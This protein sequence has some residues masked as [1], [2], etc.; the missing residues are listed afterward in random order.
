M[1]HALI[2]FSPNTAISGRTAKT[3]VAMQAIGAIVFWFIW[4]WSSPIIPNPL[5]IWQAFGKLWFQEGLGHELITSYVVNLKAL[6]YSLIL[7]LG[8]SYLTVVPAIRPLAGFVSKLRF[9]GL[10]GLT[11]IFTLTIGGGENLKIA[12]LTFGMSVFF[13]TSMAAEVASIPG[14]KFDHARTLRMGEWRVV[15]E[16]VILGKLDSAIE[17]MRQNAAIGW[18]MLTMVEGIVRS[19]GGVG[20]LLLT[21]NKHFHLSEVFAIQIMILL[22]GILQDYGIG[23]MK[24]KICPYADLNLERR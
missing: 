10:A 11:F 5:E 12:L 20:A 21:Q 17:V 13:L 1:Q 24:N 23:L 22:V 16:V 18:T 7:S 15:W 14:E 6:G 2:A 3:L 8:L 9:L 4:S 19:E